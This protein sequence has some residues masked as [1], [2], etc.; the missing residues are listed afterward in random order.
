MYLSQQNFRELMLE[1][2]HQM[3]PKICASGRRLI[4]WGSTKDSEERQAETL[5]S[6]C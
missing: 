2:S 5:G 3:T 1:D 6:K 4:V